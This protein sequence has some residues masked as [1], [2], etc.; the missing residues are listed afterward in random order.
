[1]IDIDS[2]TVFRGGTRILDRVSLRC[3]PG[4]VTAV[5]GANGAG[6]STLLGAVAGD[7]PLT[8]GRIDVCGVPA[9]SDRAREL[10]RLRAI[11]AQSSTLAFPFTVF[12]VALLGRTPHLSGSE[13][14]RDMTIAL[15]CLAA[16]G[17]DHLRDRSYP[18]LSGGERQRVQL[19][20]ALAQ[21]WDAPADRRCLILDEPTSSLDMSYQHVVL[22]LARRLADDGT[23]VAVVLHDVNLAARYA[24][25]IALLRGGRV[26]ASGDPRTVLTPDNLAAAF[27][28]RAAVLP[29]PEHDGPLVVPLAPM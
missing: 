20:R 2:V 23:T 16:A 22:A 13:G 12:E 29:H 6:K 28:V 7:Y 10:A 25:H 19:A 3:E 27:G 18:T 14:R 24:D 9:H 21:I 26:A 8:E 5:L 11:L 4:A 15:E 1:M 17:V